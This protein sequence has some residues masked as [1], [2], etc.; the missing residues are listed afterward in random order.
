VHF[1][2]VVVRSDGGKALAQGLVTVN[3]SGERPG[4]A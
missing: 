1:A 4:L 2:D 3:I